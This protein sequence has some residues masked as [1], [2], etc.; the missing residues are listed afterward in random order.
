MQHTHLLT[1]ALQTTSLLHRHHIPHAYIGGFATTLLGC[2]RSTKDLDIL[3]AL[4]KASLVAF[5]AGR[6]DWLYVPQT[7]EDYVAFLWKGI[8]GLTVLV[9]FFPTSASSTPTP[10]ST[11]TSTSSISSSTASWMAAASPPTATATDGFPPIYPYTHYTTSATLPLLHPLPLFLG[12]LAAASSRSKA[13]DGIDL[14]FLLARFPRPIQRGLKALL[15]RPTLAGAL[16]GYYH[17]GGG[18]GR[19]RGG[20]ASRAGCAGLVAAACAAGAA[21]NCH[22]DAVSRKHLWASVFVAC[23]RHPEIR[24][25]LA[26]VGVSWVGGPEVA[27]KSSLVGGKGG[28]A[29]VG[30]SVGVGGVQRGVL[31]VW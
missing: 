29:A 6:Q 25:M 24:G 16:R 23:E 21:C 28:M 15:R 4:P 10:T 3:V 9:E 7:R 19:G 12:K 8:E 5:F 31:G 17:A 14:A 20:R 18:R 22:C 1:C 27:G 30:G 2:A 11:S 26:R 13:T